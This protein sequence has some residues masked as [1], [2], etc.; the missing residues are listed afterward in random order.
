MNEWR[1]DPYSVLTQAYIIEGL[2]WIYLWI[3]SQVTAK[4]AGLNPNAKVWQEIPATQTEAPVDDTEA[5][6]WS[7]NNMAEG[8]RN[9]DFFFS[10]MHNDIKITKLK[11]YFSSRS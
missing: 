10:V 8:N 11:Y 4:G 1:Q 3:F 9:V 5:T 6:P 2:L 7:Q